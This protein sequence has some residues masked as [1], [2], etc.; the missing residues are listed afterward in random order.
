MSS[1]NF[2]GLTG[3]VTVDGGILNVGNAQLYANT[4][5]SN[6]GIGTTNPLYDLHVIGNANVVN[7]Y[8]SYVHGDGSQL[9]GIA[10]SL[11][12]IVDQGNL[13]SNTIQLISGQ[14]PV[15][16]VGLVTHEG[17]GIS[18]SNTNPTGEYQ[19]GVG[20]N[21][22]V[23]V[24]S[25]NVVTVSGNV[26]AEK[27]T[28]GTITV[29]PSYNLSHV[30]A[31][32]S[33]T[34]DTIS[35]TNATTG[36][37]AT[38][39]VLVGGELD[40]EGNVHVGKRLKFDSNVFVDSLRIADLAANLVTYDAATG[41]LFDSAGLF[42]N[43]LAVVSEQPPVALTGGSTSVSGHGTYT[44]E[45]SSGTVT[46]LFDKNNTT[47]WQTG[48]M[49]Y[50][51]DGVYGG[52]G[53]LA[54]T[55]GEW[56]KIT[57]P[58]KTILRHVKFEST[59]SS[60]KDLTIVGL[61]DDGTTWTTLKTVTNL[62]AANSTIIVDASTRH[63]T[64]GFIITATNV[65][66]TQAEIGDLR[67]F[68]ESFSIDGG[69][70]DMTVSSI[71]TIT[72]N[73]EVGT[74]NLFVDTTSGRVG[75]GKTDPTT[76]LDVVGETKISSN[77]EVGTSN[78]FVDTTTGRVGVGVNNP[79]E[80]LDIRGN[81]HL[82]RVSNVS[83]IKVDSNVVTEY[84]G[85]HDRPLRKYPEVAIPA[86]QPVSGTGPYTYAEYTIEVSSVFDNG[87][88]SQHRPT[89]V[90]DTLINVNGW[91][92][93]NGSYDGTDGTA[94]NASQPD[95]DFQSIKGSW[96]DI[97]LPHKI[98]LNKTTIRNR[99][100]SDLR[101]PKTGI[102]WA[103]N[104]GSVWKRIQ[105]FSGLLNIRN[106]VNTV[107]VNETT[108]YNQYRLQITE[109]YAF[110]SNPAV[111]IGE[112]ELY[113]YEEGDASLD[114]TLKSVYNVPATTGTQ[115]E[116]YYDAKDLTTMPS[117]VT[118]L[119]PNS[120]GGSVTGAT[121]DTTDGIES[122]KFDASSSQNITSTIDTS[123]WGTNKLHSVAFWFKADRVDG[124]YNIFQI[125]NLAA[126]EASAFWISDGSA[127]A[128]SG[129]SLN[130][131][132]YGGDSTTKVSTFSWTLNTWYH[133]ALTFDGSTKKMYVN[134]HHIDFSVGNVITTPPT[135][136][137]NPASLA[138]GS[139]NAPGDYFDGSIANFRIYGAKVLNAD[140]VKELYDYQKDYFLG[141]KSQVTLYKGH[142][143]VG[144]TEPSGQ[145]ELAGDER[146]QEYPPKAMTGYETLIPGH[147]VF[148]ASASSYY[149]SYYPWN[150]F[151]K[152][153]TD[154]STQQAVWHTEADFTN[155]TPGI[156]NAGA[157]LGEYT[158]AWLK[159]K[160]PYSIKPSKVSIHP[161]TYP[162]GTSDYDQNPKDFLILGSKDDNT[163]D[164]L[165]TQTDVVFG[166][167][168]KDFTLSPGNNT[169]NYFAISC[170]KIKHGQYFAINDMKYF[171]TPGPTTLDKGSLSLTRSLD[172][173]RISR[174]DVDTETPRP[175]KLVVDFDTT[176]NSSPTDISGKGN[177][178]KFVGNAQ[179]SAVDK[180]F[181]FDGQGS[182]YIYSS[183]LSGLPT[184]DAIYT[185][186][187]W[188]NIEPSITNV[189][190][191]IVYG[192]A[193]GPQTIATLSINT[194]YGLNAGIGSDHVKST[195]AVITPNTWHHVAC[196]KK[197]TG[198]CN[199]NMFDLYVDGVLI[200]DKTLVGGTL[201]QTIASSPL[202]LSVGGGFTGAATD[203]CNGLISNPKIYSVTLEPSEIRKLYKLGRTGRSMVISDTAVGI[204]KVPEAQL[205]VR[206][207]IS[208]DGILKPYTCA[209]SAWA[210]NTGGDSSTTGIFPAENVHFNIG[211]CYD[212]STYKFT[213]PI[214]G[215]YHM[216]WS[217][218]TNQAPDTGSRI[219]G[220]LNNSIH[221]QKGDS[222]ERHGNSLSLTLV[223]EPGDQFYFRGSSSRPLYY[224]A[225]NAHNRFSGHLIC[226]L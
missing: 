90:F 203:A 17:V 99:D 18:V 21:L 25:S 51:E 191:V 135:G 212:T 143:G 114:T 187:G 159:L 127:D 129:N 28:L 155:A 78:L 42:A 194:S 137:P 31:E 147:G 101:N 3:D 176:V 183:N 226:A 83:Q 224:Y 164:V 154:D 12:Q 103:S 95:P 165:S 57:F 120:N 209:F 222:I 166:T 145:L 67:L 193:W 150:A 210:Y 201:T 76:A 202:Y 100:S 184:G 121:L 41:E 205:D 102:L 211:N 225:A 53:T 106:H 93:K 94:I 35:L 207:N 26:L 44:I 128:N 9:T 22:L 197:A 182:S 36:L 157:S 85:P 218:F 30:T 144:V 171:G 55:G 213:A 141:S 208:C 45:A 27:M 10:A 122:F 63:A 170:T 62:S 16:N 84:T 56:A 174:Y 19:F 163:W 133:I 219:F 181:S 96:I 50:G 46:H 131:W 70:V 196:V 185:L 186:A 149:G 123:Y 32:G 198:V 115:L 204:G 72:A 6:V 87:T 180:A 126:S 60:I 220:Y 156:Y 169:Y 33:S 11:D 177:H 175:E 75:I 77:L 74:A 34:G 24:Y 139:T 134:G 68:A 15:S 130:W 23:N 88:N 162:G 47:V 54:E 140:Q 48:V 167:T 214:K 188:V 161:R 49:T 148:C 190:S 138:V 4:E 1:K 13:V 195:N 221:E 37:S 179:Y 71:S 5:T 65:G 61:N 215:I 104:N 113:G 152:N 89:N 206:G 58:Y 73:L 132:F 118:D 136:I 92:S 146:I 20:S 39:N 40:V 66:K 217:A 110:A 192:S 69:K 172:V 173:P 91:L 178:G 168:W 80:S 199:V 216:S 59:N 111:A 38:A 200:T 52:S 81:M 223:M 151:D 43:K 97:K 64:Y 107:F 189:C 98:K 29:R 125:G 160:L 117:T 119:S 142:L 7:L 158:G 105:D 108:A 109:M 124:K 116:V 153:I 82:T 8:A 112:W 79:K 14:D 2:Y 86:S